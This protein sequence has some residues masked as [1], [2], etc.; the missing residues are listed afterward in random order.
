[1][2]PFISGVG[3]RA[4]GCVPPM[5]PYDAGPDAISYP[6]FPLIFISACKTA[7]KFAKP[8]PPSS[9]KH[10]G[11]SSRAV[12]N[13]PD[14]TKWSEGSCTHTGKCQKKEKMHHFYAIPLLFFVIPAF[15]SYSTYDHTIKDCL[16]IAYNQPRILKA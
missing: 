11:A 7:V 10:G 14:K 8:P 3:V 12:D 16:A 15:L 6:T 1:M 5:P 9:E 4:G 2:C 13:Y